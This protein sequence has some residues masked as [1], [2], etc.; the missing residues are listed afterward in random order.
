MCIE[1]GI[2]CI[3]VNVGESLSVSIRK[4][5]RLNYDNTI[6]FAPDIVV[7]VDRRET[8]STPNKGNHRSHA[9]TTHPNYNDDTLIAVRH[10]MRRHETHSE[11]S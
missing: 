10:H 5:D 11:I 4:Y 6:G 9:S 3:Q 8:Q 1:L 7:D 2:P